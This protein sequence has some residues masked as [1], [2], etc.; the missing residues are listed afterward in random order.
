MARKNTIHI[1]CCLMTVRLCSSWS[2][3][4]PSPAPL[5]VP[6]REGRGE[7][8]RRALRRPTHERPQEHKPVRELNR[9]GRRCPR[10]GP[11]S[12]DADGG[13][14]RV[15]PRPAERVPYGGG[16]RTLGHTRVGDH[17]H[18]GA[19]AGGISDHLVDIPGPSELEYADH[20]HQE[21]H[22]HHRELH[23]R[24]PVRRPTEESRAV[25]KLPPA[26]NH[27]TS[28][29]TPMASPY[30]TVIAPCDSRV[31]RYPNRPKQARYFIIA[32]LRDTT[33]PSARRRNASSS[34][35]APPTKAIIRNAPI[36]RTGPMKP[37]TATSNLTSPPP[38]MP[39]VNG[40]SESSSANPAPSTPSTSAV[41]PSTP[42][43]TS[44][45][46]SPATVNQFG[47]RRQR[48]SNHTP[49]PSS[50]V[51]VAL[52]ITDLVQW[53]DT[54][55]LRGAGAG[56]T[57]RPWLRSLRLE[58]RRYYFG[59]YGVVGAACSESATAL[60]T[61]PVRFLM[62]TRTAIRPIAT[63]AIIRAYSTM[64]CPESLLQST[65]QRSFI[66]SSWPA[67]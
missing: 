30:G 22:E 20:Q 65:F 55:A 18:A 24:L 60:Y 53:S 32:K 15:Q 26:A 43:N 12:R 6:H 27:H 31:G 64:P 19:S 42:R 59:T 35:S 7:R 29:P 2:A 28:E 33:S 56:S 23:D 25:H 62:K 49:R 8:D 41:T 44:A 21:Q 66:D 54:L 51:S 34:A 50:V 48:R 10:P 17:R 4:I 9:Y 40:G 38:S 36:R 16:A 13:A 39:S 11:P 37:P 45:A 58:D 1:L 3:A 14:A 63:S 57:V 61:S 67:A 46:P 5:F 47:I 52:A